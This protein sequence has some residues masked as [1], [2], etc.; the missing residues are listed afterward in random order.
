MDCNVTALTV[1][2]VLPEIEPTDAVIVDE[3]AATAVA[4]PAEFMVAVAEVAEFQV[5]DD[6]TAEDPSE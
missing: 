1:M 3:P 6:K 2:R 4:S 5:G